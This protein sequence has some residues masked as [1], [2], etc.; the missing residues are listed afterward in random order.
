[1]VNPKFDSLL[2]EIRESEIKKM[3]FVIGDWVLDTGNYKLTLNHRMNTTTPNVAILEGTNVIQ[4]NLIEVVDAN[5]LRLWVTGNPDL[6]FAGTASI[7]K[8]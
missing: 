1:M 6:R 2:N 4:V 8:A 5:N 3:S 7:T